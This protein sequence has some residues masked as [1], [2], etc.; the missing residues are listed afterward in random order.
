MVKAMSDF[1]ETLREY[2]A[3]TDAGLDVILPKRDNYQKEIYEA[4]RYSL[5]GGGKRIRP[6]LLF[7]TAELFGLDVETVKPL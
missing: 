1:Y 3:Y 6:V 7:V 2:A 5:L 4:M